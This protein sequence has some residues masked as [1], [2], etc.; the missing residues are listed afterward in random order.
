MNPTPLPTFSS[1]PPRYH[2][3]VLRFWEE[4]GDTPTATAWRFSLEDPQTARRQG[5]AS[6]EALVAW[7]Q[8][9]TRAEAEAED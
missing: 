3:Y 2:S 8:A 7:L 5:F 1:Q 9:E 4:R 6:L